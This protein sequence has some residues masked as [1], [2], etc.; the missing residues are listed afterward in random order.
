[1]DGQRELAK[2]LADL[3]SGGKQQSGLAADLVPP[4]LDSAYRVAGMVQEV[5]GWEVAGW[6]IAATN[7]EMQRA[8]RTGRPIYGRVYAPKIRPSPA[9]FEH[10]TLCSPIPEAEYQ[11][12]LAIDL[13][14][15]EEPYAV[16]E[17]TEA[18]ASL[19]PGLE[20]AE[21]RFIHDENFPPLAA[22]LADGSGSGTLVHGPAIEDWRNQDISGQ[23]VVLYR[24]DE[25]RRSGTAAAA[26]DHPMVPLTW[27]ANELSRTGVGLKAG[28]MISTGTMT[29]MIRAARGQTLR[30][31]FGHFG[32]VSLRLA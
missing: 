13:P 32:E 30:A 6:K 22:I 12:R 10:A 26:L 7:A 24:D 19:H 2:R 4:D 15:R 20:L 3:L 5:L 23:E 27:L 21:C 17:V 9:T 31:D 29:G 1:M 18:V 16:E 25:Q 11:A 28:Q 14:P 8:L